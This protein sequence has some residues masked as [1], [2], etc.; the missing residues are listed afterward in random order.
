MQGAAGEY[1]HGMMLYRVAAAWPK[2]L[3]KKSR[4][5][6]WKKVVE[7]YKMLLE[8]APVNVNSTSSTSPKRISLVNRILSKIRRSRSIIAE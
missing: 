5:K 6:E 4:V 2:T 1:H 8:S 7:V 3:D